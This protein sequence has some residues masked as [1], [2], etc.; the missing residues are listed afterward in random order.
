MGEIDRVQPILRPMPAPRLTDRVQPGS[1][2]KHHSPQERDSLDLSNSDEI[3][4]TP[5]DEEPIPQPEPGHR[6][7]LTA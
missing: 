6:L 3:E 1:E 4:E 2:R 5:V 7:D